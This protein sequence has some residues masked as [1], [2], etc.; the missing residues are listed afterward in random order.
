MPIPLSP[1]KSSQVAA[2]GYDQDTKTLAVRFNS[3]GLYHYTGVEP[4]AFAALQS[5]QSIGSHL[6]QSIKGAYAFQR[7]E[8]PT[9]EQ[10]S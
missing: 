7:V 1:V 4:E 3:G 6:A 8:E 9:D 5:A 10:G 2:V